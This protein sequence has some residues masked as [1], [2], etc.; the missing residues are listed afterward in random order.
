MESGH[1]T[2]KTARTHKTDIYN[3]S[4]IMHA[5][6]GRINPRSASI[7]IPLPAM[8][9]IKMIRET[10]EL[11]EFIAAATASGWAAMDTEFLRERTYSPELCLIQIAHAD[12]A[13]CI[14]PQA[15][16][17]LSPLG[18][19]LANPAVVKIFHSCRQDL[20]ALDTRMPL[21]AAAVYDTQLA[22]AFCG[23]GSQASYAALVAAVC[24]VHLPKTHTRTDWSRRPLSAAQL[25]YAMDDVKYL[26]P[27]RRHLDEL[28]AQH[29]RQQWHR[30]ECVAAAHPA[31]YRPAAD[32]W[33]RLKGLGRLDTMGRACAQRLTGWREQKARD[34][35]RPR[36]WILPTPALLAVCRQ[37]PRT[38]AMLAEVDDLSP[39]IVKNS[40]RDI[41][42]LVERSAADGGEMRDDS[43][44][45]PEPLSAEQRHRV[46]KIMDL[47]ARRAAETDISQALFAN[48][49]EVEN[50]VRGDSEQ[51]LFHG[52]RAQLAGDEIRAEYS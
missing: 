20:E 22:A 4:V 21:C 42:N 8:A 26:A 6:G 35:N 15:V 11:A 30:D 51:P 32:P 10:R 46:K 39:G 7:M 19:L 5:N 43:S 41:L 27:L 33:Q 23:Y 13:A 29:G 52:W 34:C 18:A 45:R 44:T 17:D 31:N 50:F 49:R 24:A 48:R 1:T 40:G 16:E 47:L 38:M 28:L 25:Q 12:A 14:D 37:R 3:V 2:I 9:T 36:G